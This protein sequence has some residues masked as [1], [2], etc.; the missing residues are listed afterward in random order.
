MVLTTEQI[1]TSPVAKIMILTF[2]FV[3]SAY[4]KQAR[5]ST[6]DEVLAVSRGMISFARKWHKTQH[7]IK[8][9]EFEVYSQV[10]ETNGDHVL[11]VQK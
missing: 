8:L 10:L 7:D 1:S 4:N 5:T 9:L 6:C 3:A 11:T 2:V